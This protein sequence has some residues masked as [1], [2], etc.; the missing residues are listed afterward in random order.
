MIWN[1]SCWLCCLFRIYIRN[2]KSTNIDKD[3]EII[4]TEFTASSF[5]LYIIIY[6][7]IYIYIYIP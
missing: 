4:T 1:I 6:I 7:Y 2:L 3:K 5:T